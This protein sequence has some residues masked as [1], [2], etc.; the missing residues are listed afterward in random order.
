MEIDGKNEI[1]KRTKSERKT[2]KK[3]IKKDEQKM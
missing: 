3:K 1:R 2:D